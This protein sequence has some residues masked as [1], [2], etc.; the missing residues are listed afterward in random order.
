MGLLGALVVLFSYQDY[1]LDIF[2]KWK[3]LGCF[4]VYALGTSKALS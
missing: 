4:S 3:S 1:K 2:L